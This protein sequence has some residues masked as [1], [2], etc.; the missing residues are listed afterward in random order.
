MDVNKLSRQLVLGICESDSEDIAIVI[1][2]GLDPIQ[3]KWTHLLMSR[4]TFLG[5]Q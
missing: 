1:A 4:Y 5:E 2:I 3:E